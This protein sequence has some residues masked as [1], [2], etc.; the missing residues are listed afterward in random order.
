MRSCN[1]EYC[2][3]VDDRIDIVS[4]VALDNPRSSITEETWRNDDW[5]KFPFV[6]WLR[7]VSYPIPGLPLKFMFCKIPDFTFWQGGLGAGLSV[8]V[9]ILLLVMVSHE[10]F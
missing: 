7:P 6:L 3:L 9:S 4:A 5:D 2:D 10:Q 1:V 8:I